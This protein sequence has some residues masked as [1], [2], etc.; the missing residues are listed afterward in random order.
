MTRV[1]GGFFVGTCLVRKHRPH[2]QARCGLE[3]SIEPVSGELRHHLVVPNGLVNHWFNIVVLKRK[4]L[5]PGKQ[6]LNLLRLLND[7]DTIP[8]D[9]VLAAI[10]FIEGDWNQDRRVMANEILAGAGTLLPGRLLSTFVTAELTDAE[11]KAAMAERQALVERACLLLPTMLRT[12]RAKTQEEVR[13][14]LQLILDCCNDLPYVSAAVHKRRGRREALQNL[15]AMIST[16]D[17][18]TQQLQANEHQVSFEFESQIKTVRR[19]SILFEDFLNE[20]RQ[21]KL[22]AQHVIFLD[23]IGECEI[24]IADNRV[25]THIVGYAYRIFSWI[26]FPSFSTTPGSDFSLLCAL[27]YELAIGEADASFS[28]AIGKFARSPERKEIDE[29]HLES[30]WENSEEAKRLAEADN[31]APYRRSEENLRKRLEILKRFEEWIGPGELSEQ[32]IHA[33]IAEAYQ[34]YEKAQKIPGPFLVWA[35]QISPEDWQQKMSE[36]S[37]QEQRL[38]ELER[39]IGKLRR[40][41]PEFR[42]S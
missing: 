41:R 38:L 17:Q 1:A 24:F 35:S 36:I 37:E 3:G 39:N 23:E 6:M 7:A 26:G 32:T 9:V 28:G 11:A 34:D 21:M 13:Y 40:S 42:N 14:V 12:T 18:L 30:H 25:K 8:F 16:L 4:S 10:N 5:P 22:S 20:A 15:K 2:S 31:F 27:I 19:R 29:D 33:W